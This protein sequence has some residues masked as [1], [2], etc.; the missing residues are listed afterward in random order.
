MCPAGRLVPLF[1]AFMLLV[2][3]GLARADQAPDDETPV[4]PEPPPPPPVVYGDATPP[5]P[6]ND[7]YGWQIMLSDVAS[8]GLSAVLRDNGGQAASIAFLAG[9]AIIHIAHG[10]SQ[11][12]LG[13]VVLRC[14]A[15]TAGALAG[16]LIGGLVIRHD[17]ND[18]PP[19]GFIDGNMLLGLAIGAAV[20]ELTAL[21]LDYSVLSAADPPR[22]RDR[23]PG[24][25]GVAF[26][27]SSQGLTLSLGGTF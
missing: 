4:V 6:S 21:V 9:P 17:D 11:A 14:G 25:L 26:V 8:L 10:R 20:G 13:S 12:A 15:P 2:G 7:W 1:A 27:P 23:R 22:A 19:G 16:L 5:P 24:A 3:P 18:G